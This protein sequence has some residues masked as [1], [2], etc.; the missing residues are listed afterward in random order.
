MQLKRCAIP[1]AFTS[2]GAR[3]PRNGRNIPDLC[4]PGARLV[5]K[6]TTRRTF[7][8]PLWDTQCI[9]LP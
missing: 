7:L 8:V 3:R 4:P 2:M 9:I 5:T 1:L 6:L